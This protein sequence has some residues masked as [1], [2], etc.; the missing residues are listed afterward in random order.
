MSMTLQNYNINEHLKRAIRNKIEDKTKV[1]LQEA[2]LKLDDMLPSIVAEVLV[3]VME[4]EN[5]IS[6]SRLIEFRISKN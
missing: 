4:S 5:V 3:E 6:M 2:K 1:L